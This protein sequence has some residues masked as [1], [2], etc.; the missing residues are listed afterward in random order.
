MKIFDIGK[1]YVE[2]VPDVRTQKATDNKA[3]QGFGH[4]VYKNG[5]HRR[6]PS[7]G[8]CGFKMTN[9]VIDRWPLTELMLKERTSI[10]YGPSGP[11]QLPLGIPIEL[12]PD[13]RLQP[14]DR[15]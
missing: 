8:R 13:L 10:N 6:H 14:R 3:H 7:N 5:D 9:Q 12:Y 1:E 4:R 2:V 11:R 15:W